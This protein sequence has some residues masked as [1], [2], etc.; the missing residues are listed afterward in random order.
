MKII[1]LYI[2]LL[3]CA[4]HACDICI[5]LSQAEQAAIKTAL[6]NAKGEKQANKQN[7]VRLDGIIYSDKDSWTIWINGSPIKSGESFDDLRILNVTP[8]SVEIIWSPNP[9]QHHQI[10]LKPN[11]TF[12]TAKELS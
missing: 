11:E 5:M 7:S 4:T 9:D 3:S 8:D 6:E 2:G 12:Q 10:C 1:L